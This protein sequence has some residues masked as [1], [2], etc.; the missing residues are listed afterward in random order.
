MT[1]FIPFPTPC[2]S[3]FW[4]PWTYTPKAEGC[5]YSSEYREAEKTYRKLLDRKTFGRRKVHAIQTETIFKCLQI[6]SL[7]LLSGSERIPT[8]FSSCVLQAM[9]GNCMLMFVFACTVDVPVC[10]W[11]CELYTT[12]GGKHNHQMCDY[13]S[14]PPPGCIYEGH[15]WVARQVRFKT[16]N[17]V[18][19]LVSHGAWRILSERS[20]QMAAAKHNQE[21]WERGEGKQ[22]N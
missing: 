17:P 2:S 14:P 19:G 20:T 10:H 6:Q 7:A 16:C 1:D 5:D 9:P 15:T 18:Q 21:Q 22:G 4:R 13:I 11:P 12:L 8:Q 3:Y